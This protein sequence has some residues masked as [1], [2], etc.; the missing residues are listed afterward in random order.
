MG[1]AE[2]TALSCHPGKDVSLYPAAW[3]RLHL[4]QGGWGS[5]GRLPRALQLPHDLWDGV[6]MR[7]LWRGRVRAEGEEF[8]LVREATQAPSDCPPP[9]L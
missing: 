2:E 9:G 1:R 5:P 3:L 8:W 6:E 4:D 7:G